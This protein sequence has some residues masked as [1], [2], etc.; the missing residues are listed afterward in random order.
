MHNNVKFTI[1]YLDGKVKKAV[2]SRQHSAHHQAMGGC[3][4]GQLQPGQRQ[5]VTR[6]IAQELRRS[7]LQRIAGQQATGRCVLCG[8]QTA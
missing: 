1:E 8:T 2:S 6:K 4:A 3:V 7:Q 5:V